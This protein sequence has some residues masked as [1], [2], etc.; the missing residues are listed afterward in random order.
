MPHRPRSSARPMSSR[1]GAKSRFRQ[2]VAESV[3][4]ARAVWPIGRLEPTM[5]VVLDTRAF[6]A[7]KPSLDAFVERYKSDREKVIKLSKVFQEHSARWKRDTQHWSSVTKMVMHPSYRRI[8]GMGPDALPLILHE[9]KERPDHWF[10]ALNAI[11]GEDP[12]P[13]SGTFDEAVA[14]WISWGIRD[15][16]LH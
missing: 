8:M 12:T 9:L 7:D 3:L 10:V 5:V 6:I 11:S 4:A 13:P 2:E 15:G 16:Y 14:A 1:R